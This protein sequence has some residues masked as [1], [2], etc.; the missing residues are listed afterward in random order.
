M[1]LRSLV[2]G[3]AGFIG[4]HLVDR[5]LREGHQV[6]GLDNFA[7]GRPE[8]IAH[9]AEVDRFEFCELD[10]CDQD[11]LS[12]SMYGVDRVF[13]IAGIGDIVPSIEAPLDYYRAN[14]D[15]TIN[16]LEAARANGVKRF[17]YAASSTCYGI[18]ETIPTPEEHPIRPKY[19]YAL[20]Y[21]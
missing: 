11:A 12:R 18:A 7:S 3:A 14:V 16:C 17:L 19:P 2:T 13:H 10:I 5:L 8:N 6:I 15:G 4:S 9:L 21:L 20:T 1:T